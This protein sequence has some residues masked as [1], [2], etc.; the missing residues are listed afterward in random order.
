[1]QKIILSEPFQ[2]LNTSEIK[3][4]KLRQKPAIF[5]RHFTSISILC[6]RVLQV[7]LT[8][9]R[10]RIEVSKFV[11]QEIHS[12]I[13]Y[14]HSNWTHQ[15]VTSTFNR[16][17][18]KVS[19][20]NSCQNLAFIMAPLSW[21]NQQSNLCTCFRRIS[22]LDNVWNGTKPHFAAKQLFRSRRKGGLDR[23]S[24]NSSA[25]G[26]WAVRWEQEHGPAPS[27]S[28]LWLECDL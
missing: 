28:E 19:N 23:E 18:T 15:Q 26:S 16:H 27:P 20:Y 4:Y 7:M 6:R 3:E 8:T 25:V 22:T 1:M 10:L 17:F 11:K 13:T 5:W 9:S 14:M 24:N 12:L 2:I 21:M